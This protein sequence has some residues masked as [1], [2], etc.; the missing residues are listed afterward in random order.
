MSNLV[1]IFCMLMT[2]LDV[3]TNQL[4]KCYR[5]I[6]LNK[7]PKIVGWNNRAFFKQTVII[8]F[9][10][11]EALKLIFWSLFRKLQENK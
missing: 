3:E 4:Y 10:V 5:T 6:G 7:M 11:P 1:K 8:S 9:R 2:H